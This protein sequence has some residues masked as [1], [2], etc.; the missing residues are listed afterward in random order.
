M[1]VTARMKNGD[2]SNSNHAVVQGVLAAVRRG[3]GHRVGL[4]AG[5]ALGSGLTFTSAGLVQTAS[6]VNERV[7]VA[8]L[9]GHALCSKGGLVQ[10]IGG[11]DH[12]MLFL[13]VCTV[14]S[15][16]QI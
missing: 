2:G 3:D 1:T 10:L 8:A 14:L 12:M 11:V 6:D 15:P 13:M 7:L 16:A 9:G 4:T 5:T